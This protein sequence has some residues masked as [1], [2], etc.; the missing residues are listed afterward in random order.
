MAILLKE[1]FVH[2]VDTME[3]SDQLIADARE[4]TKGVVSSQSNYRTKKSK[5]EIVEDWYVVTI[6]HDYTV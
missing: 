1:T 3:E 2:R 6:T 4:N 5:G